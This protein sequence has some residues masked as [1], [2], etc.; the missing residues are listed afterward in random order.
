MVEGRRRAQLLVARFGS[1]L[2]VARAAAGLTQLR[3]A[4]LAGVSQSFVSLVE[5]GRRRAQWSTACAM[6]TATGH[7]LSLKLFPARSVSLRDSGQFRAVEHIVSQAHDSWHSRLEVSVAPGDARAA[8]LLLIRPDEV[9]HIEVE[10]TLV[11][12]QAQLRA[13][14]RKRSVVV[15]SFDRP[16]RLVLAIPGTRNARRL[17]AALRPGLSA[18]LPHPSARAWSSIRSGRPLGGDALLFLESPDMTRRYSG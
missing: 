11:D 17:V 8:D 1:E 3:L 15:Q 14:Q 16:V 4:E 13:P 9:L 2:R 10:R 5:G 7:D 18:A 6:A 12:F